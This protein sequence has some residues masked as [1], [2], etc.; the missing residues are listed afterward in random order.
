MSRD[1]SRLKTKIRR[2]EKDVDRKVNDAVEE[3][4]NATKREMER[5]I[6]SSGAL[7][8]GDL[9]RSL[10]VESSRAEG[11]YRLFTNPL[12]APHA[13]F[14]EFGTGIEGRISDPFTDI[15]ELRFEAPSF[16]PN[17]IENI[18]VWVDTKPVIPRGDYSREEL[19]FA[20]AWSISRIGTEANPFFRPAW[21]K[22]EP[23]L[24]ASVEEAISSAVDTHF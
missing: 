16:G 24:K 12:I 13:A 18:Q 6:V 4:L 3:S 20:I 10:D 17:L 7:W 14:V 21:L 23:I 9:A 1:V 22:F 8:K 11:H 5:E 19:A 15:Q 2:F